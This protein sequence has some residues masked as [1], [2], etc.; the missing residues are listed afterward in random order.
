MIR[1][2][3]V[4]IALLSGV[5]LAVL[6]LGRPEHLAAI[7]GAALP[8]WTQTAADDASLIS[9]RAGP[10]PGPLALVADWRL[11]GIGRAGPVWRVGLSGDGVRLAGNLTAPTGGEAVLRA[12]SGPVD[13]ARLAV[14]EAP[15]DF[16]GTLVFTGASLGLDLRRGAVSTLE[17]GGL[18]RDIVLGQQAFG[19]GRMEAR[20]EAD[21]RWLVELTLAGGQA[22]A[23]AE[24][25]AL[26]GLLQLHVDEDRTDLLPAG[27]G[28][29][30][31]AEGNRLMVS[32]I[33]PIRPPDKPVDQGRS[34]R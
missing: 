3:A 12:V 33:L 32:H 25:D 34:N 7:T 24:G 2:L 13:M 29:P 1:A 5:A 4:A 26:G 27:W 21:G 16:S 10:L 18:A 11:S 6:T 17:A 31:P 20:L 30:L 9:G 8:G 23:R 22:S 19:E 14:W 28:H 15:P